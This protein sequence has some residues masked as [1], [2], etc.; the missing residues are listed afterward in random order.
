[1][2]KSWILPLI[3]LFC[4]LASPLI[5]RGFAGPGGPVLVAELPDSFSQTNV[6]LPY[7]LVPDH[8]SFVLGYNLQFQVINEKEVL[9][10]DSIIGP[11]K[12]FQT[13]ACAYFDF[14]KDNPSPDYA[15]LVGTLTNGQD[16]FIWWGIIFHTA[17]DDIIHLD[18]DV[19]YGNEFMV[20]GTST[21]LVGFS[22]DF[23]RLVVNNL[24]YVVDNGMI[25]YDY[26]VVWQF[27]S[28]SPDAVA[29]GGQR[30]AV[31]DF[32]KFLNPLQTRF[33]LPIRVTRYPIAVQYGP[34]IDPSTFQAV[35]NG[36]DI[37]SQYAFEPSPGTSKT[38][39]IPLS[40]GRNILKLQVDGLI[41][42]RTATDRDTLTII[43]P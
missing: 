40:P 16:E 33:S 43:C 1:M 23:V 24:T 30:S 8:A 6:S 21:D 2:R 14:N 18:Y 29:G 31:N 20:F 32:L 34:S 19:G 41:A 7:G 5:G 13:D 27:W 28:G 36:V 39:A 35:L 11:G 38:V 15:N 3:A 42:G 26:D 4:V 12:Q 25:S 9:T 10:S 17:T 22:I 37:T